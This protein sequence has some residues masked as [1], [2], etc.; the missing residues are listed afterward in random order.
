MTDNSAIAVSLARSTAR[1]GETNYNYSIISPHILVTK[2]NRQLS[3]AC[4]PVLDTMHTKK[5]NVMEILRTN[6]ESSPTVLHISIPAD[7]LCV[8]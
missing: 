1:K 4:Y 8:F 6:V 5:L 7:S 2:S 3:R